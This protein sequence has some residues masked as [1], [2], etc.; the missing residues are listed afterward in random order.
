M[1]QYID[2]Y[3]KSDLNDKKAHD[4]FYDFSIAELY[5]NTLDFIID[6]VEELTSLFNKKEKMSEY[7]F[8]TKVYNILFHKEKQFYLGI[9]IL[10]IA[11]VIIL[12]S[13]E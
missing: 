9:I 7:S 6:L 8:K 12:A 11:I 3:E 13:E 2:I 5:K 10:F 4:M 1:N